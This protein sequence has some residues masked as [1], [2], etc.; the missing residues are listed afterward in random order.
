MGAHTLLRQRSDL[1]A[2][3]YV[4]QSQRF[5]GLRSGPGLSG[6]VVPYRSEGSRHQPRRGAA[7]DGDLVDFQ[8]YTLYRVDRSI[9]IATSMDMDFPMTYASLDY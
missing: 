7:D 3:Y 5:G 2:W 4:S 1:G 9:C 8:V 6:R